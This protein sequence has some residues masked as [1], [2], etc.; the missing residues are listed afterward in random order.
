MDTSNN[1]LKYN[2]VFPKKLN[3]CHGSIQRKT[4]I[5]DNK[6]LADCIQLSLLLDS[7]HYKTTS[8]RVLKQMVRL[9]TSTRNTFESPL[10]FPKLIS[11][12]LSWH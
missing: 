6:S 5:G 4:N 10:L 11:S 2:K 8:T 3:N 1:Y 9:V 7:N 12:C